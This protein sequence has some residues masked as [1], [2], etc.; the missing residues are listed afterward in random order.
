[1]PVFTADNKP[2]F[3]GI[4]NASIAITVNVFSRPKYSEF[5][6]QNQ[7]GI[8]VPAD[9]TNV[10]ILEEHSY[11]NDIIY[12]SKVKVKGYK[13]TMKIASLTPDQIQKYTFTIK[14]EFGERQ[15][16]ISVNTESKYQYSTLT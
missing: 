13:I 14:N 10:K 4:L 12:N 8:R 7:N 11:I 5:L 2:V 9:V 3:Y 6:I 15:Y 16:N 1:M